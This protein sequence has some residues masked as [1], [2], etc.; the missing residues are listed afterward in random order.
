MQNVKFYD[1]IYY[2]VKPYFYHICRYYTQSS[3]STTDMKGIFFFLL[4]TSF[5]YS[6]LVL[7]FNHLK[8]IYGV[9]F[10]T[11][12]KKDQKREGPR[13]SK[14]NVPTGPAM[15]NLLPLELYRTQKILCVQKSRGGGHLF[16]NKL[17]K[18]YT[19]FFFLD[20]LYSIW[21]NLKKRKNT[22]IFILNGNFFLRGFNILT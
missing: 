3:F 17:Y 16:W 21:R 12:K 1:L 6:R 19:G 9:A 5:A 20:I 7:T 8:N 2:R 10:K 15:G 14:I 18:I 22:N 13:S 4:L 11:Q